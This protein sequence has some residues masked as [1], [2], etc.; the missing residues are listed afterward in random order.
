L[1]LDQ[2]KIVPEKIRIWKEEQEKR[3]LEKDSAEE[4]AKELLKEQAKKELQDWY[5]RH[6]ESIAKTKVM[7]R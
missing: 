4:E 1:F 5:K 3:L 6:D 7:N 2:P